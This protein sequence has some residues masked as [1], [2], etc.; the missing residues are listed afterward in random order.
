[1]TEEVLLCQVV[2]SVACLTLNRPK[3]MNSLNLAMLTALDRR[4]TEIAANNDIRVLVLTGAGAAFCAGADLKEIL[5]GQGLAAG[6]ADFL[7][8]AKV[9]FDRLRNFPKPVIAA[10]NGITM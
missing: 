6:E 1:M 3:A 4:M 7:D 10:L 9:T 2:D 8:R 5:A